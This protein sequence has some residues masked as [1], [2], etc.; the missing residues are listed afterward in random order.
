VVRALGYRLDFETRG[1]RV[2]FTV[3]REWRVTL[4]LQ[5]DIDG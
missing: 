2:G 3:G 5:E 4:Q 1:D